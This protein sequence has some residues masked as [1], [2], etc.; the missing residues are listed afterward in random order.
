MA[1]FW[2]QDLATKVLSFIA[3]GILQQQAAWAYALLC[4]G[5]Q[6]SFAQAS[7]LANGFS[8]FLLLSAGYLITDLGAWVSWLR[9]ISPFFYGACTF[10]PL[11]LLARPVPDALTARQASTGS[12]AFSS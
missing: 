10:L 4:C 9:W 7:M 12:L 1:G 3:Q 5:V 6:R 8:I 2:R 11:F